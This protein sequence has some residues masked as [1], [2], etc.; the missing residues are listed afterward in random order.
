MLTKK[1]SAEM[2]RLMK[3]VHRLKATRREQERY[4]DLSRRISTPAVRHPVD[5]SYFVP[6][7]P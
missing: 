3:L 7:R 2:Y 4:Q 6:N 5:G 1:E